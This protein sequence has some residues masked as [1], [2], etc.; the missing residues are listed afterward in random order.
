M[1]DR[2]TARLDEL[3]AEKVRLVELLVEKR[4]AI[5]THAVTRGL[6]ENAKLK[7]SGIEWLDKIPEHWQAMKL[8]FACKLLRD[9]THLP[10]PRVENGFPLLSVRKFGRWRIYSLFS[11]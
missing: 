9:G 2:E 10:P 4:R 5:I 6:D 7:D 11:R 8:K 3:I 1:L